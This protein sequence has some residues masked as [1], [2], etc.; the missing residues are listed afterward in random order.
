[1]RWRDCLNCLPHRT[2]AALPRDGIAIQVS[3]AS[4]RPPPTFP[5]LSWPPKIS[6]SQIGGLEGVPARFGVYQSSSRIAA[7]RVALVF[8]FFGRGTPAVA[9]LARANAQLR[10]SRLR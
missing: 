8:V 5:K 1:V 2:L 9:E 3:I 6:R 7:R 10:R 4:E